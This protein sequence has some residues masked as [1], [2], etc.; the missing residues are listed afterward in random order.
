L[1]VGAGLLVRTMSNLAQVQSGYTTE[2][3][4]TMTV[5]MVQGDWA[6]FHTRAL[7]RVSTVPGV[8]QAAF[9]WGVPLTGNNWPGSV[10]IEGRPVASPSDRVP[11]PQRSVTPGYFSLLGLTL[12]EGR[13]F[14]SSDAP[15]AP[16]VAIVNQSFVDR[17]FAPANA[18]GK[19]LW[20]RGRDQP[21]TDIVGVVSNGRTD[22][23]TRTADPEV[24]FS[25]W[26]RS[27]FSKDLVVRAAGDPRA[28]M[29]AVQRELRAVDPTAAIENI[30]TLDQIRA[31]SLASRNFAM[32]LLVG[33]SL[34]ASVLTLVGIYG[35]LSLSV[36]ARRRDFAIRSAIGAQ[37]RDIRNLVFAEGFRLIAAGVVSGI[38]VAM[39][40]S[41][42][43]ASLLFEVEPADPA[44][45]A[46][47]GLLFAA[48]SLLACWVPSRRAARVNPLA[49]LRSE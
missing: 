15:N 35:V 11:V 8:Q 32:R 38:V 6:N 22:D 1:L 49:A 12:T 27:A 17:Y 29:T 48:V 39:V 4:L 7:E 10:E 23:L 3:V 33:F 43:L 24:Y 42:V 13:D 46:G 28:L 34:V 19:K 45:L 21:P 26:Q 9:A 2:H 36:A 25:L 14:R 20:F 16:P 5:T 40:L 41:R 47:A 44:T 18:I 31:D 30:R 37:H